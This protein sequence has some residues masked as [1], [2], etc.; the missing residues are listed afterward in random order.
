MD[1]VKTEI[2]KTKDNI[3]TEQ[4]SRGEE[5]V[6]KTIKTIFFCKTKK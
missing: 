5:D 4:G 3:K 2:F 6:Q 1:P